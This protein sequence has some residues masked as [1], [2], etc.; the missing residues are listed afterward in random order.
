MSRSLL[1]HI[2]KNIHD[3]ALVP[4]GATIV[5]AVSGGADSV[6]L[7]QLLA[8]MSQCD[9]KKEL[10]VAHLDHGLRPD[11]ADDACFVEKMAADLGLPFFRSGLMFSS[12]LNVRDGDW[13]KRGG[14]RGVNFLGELPIDINRQ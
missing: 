3:H 4:C 7:L 8:Q 13:K 6:C 1:D 14:K 11:S 5:V 2:A 10:V 12:W 9:A